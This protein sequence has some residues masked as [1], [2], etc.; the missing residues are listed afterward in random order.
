MA[1]PSATLPTSPVD[2]DF[3]AYTVALA[4]SV[5]VASEADDGKVEPDLTSL[6]GGELDPEDT[7]KISRPES[8][9]L[10]SWVELF[11]P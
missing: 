4:Q 11:D 2:G 3:S 5:G 10:V 8:N 7:A 6:R 9:G 1:G